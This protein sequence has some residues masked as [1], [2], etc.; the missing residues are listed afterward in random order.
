MDK[1]CT[2]KWKQE[3]HY[4]LIFLYK[5]SLC[6]INFGQR[7]MP[8]SNENTIYRWQNNHIIPA[9]VCVFQTSR[10]CYVQW[11]YVLSTPSKPKHVPLLC[12]KCHSSAQPNWFTGRLRPVYSTLIWLYTVALNQTHTTWQRGTYNVTVLWLRLYKF[13]F[14]T[15]TFG[16][17]ESL[18]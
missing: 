8:L 14:C 16:R 4:P 15:D 5:P 12:N 18:L 1:D 2:R 6:L 10:N 7:R 17:L 3:I 9:M 13:Y 11:C